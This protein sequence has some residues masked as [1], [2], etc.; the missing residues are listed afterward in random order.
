MGT[1]VQEQ[2][3]LFADQVGSTKLLAQIGDEAMVAVHNRL[4]SIFTSVV[5]RHDGEVLSDEG[6]GGSAVFDDTIAAALAALDM[7]DECKQPEPTHAASIDLRVAIHSGPVIRTAGAAVGLAV[8]LTARLCDE[9]PAGFTLI[10]D[11]A[12]ADLV[13]H[14]ELRIT[15]FGQRSAKGIDQPLAVN[16]LTRAA[17]PV[18]TSEQ[19]EAPTSF[20]SSPLL[21]QTATSGHFVGRD[22]ELDVLEQSLARAAAGSPGIVLIE[23]V[24]GTG[25]STLTRR[26][27]TTA[28]AD[29]A[30]CLVG[31]SDEALDDPFHEIIEMP[32]AH[33]RRGPAT[34]PR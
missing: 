2:A 7:L 28:I 5:A 29:G 31:R 22:T 3:I 30:V 15:P 10:S 12:A 4:W 25:K 24:P 18:P 16:V 6:D 1:G 33:G 8:H 27:A 21:D 34:P 26:L 20:R 19:E 32:K 9:A 13:N 17:D 11:E 14:H 23:G